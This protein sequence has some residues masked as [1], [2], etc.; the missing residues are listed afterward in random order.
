[1]FNVDNEIKMITDEED[2]ICVHEAM[3]HCLTGHLLNDRELRQ[4]LYGMPKPRDL[5]EIIMAT[6]FF[7]KEQALH[8]IRQALAE[9]REQ[10]ISWRKHLDNPFCEIQCTFSKETGEGI[11]KNT[12]FQERIPVHG[13]RVILIRG[14]S[15]GRAFYI[16][17]AYPN[18][19][20]EDVD[21]VY[22]AIGRWQE[23]RK[24]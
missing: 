12:D 8:D 22:D 14:D 23:K 1:M 4:K 5:D 2:F 13:I 16:K 7:S 6:R 11:C 24:G 9:N 19:T 15:L 18:C 3:G 10:I 20:F 17:T 21:V